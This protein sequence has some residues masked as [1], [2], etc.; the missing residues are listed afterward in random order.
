MS[1]K[2]SIQLLPI[3]NGNHCSGEHT[4]TY[5]ARFE[6][7]VDSKVDYLCQHHLTILCRTDLDVKLALSQIGEL[8]LITEDSFKLD[9][10]NRKRKS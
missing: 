3:D 5:P 10:S 2:V 4:E 9:M 7:T 8:T 6:I 1:K